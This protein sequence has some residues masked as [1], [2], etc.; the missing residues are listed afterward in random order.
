M[1]VARVSKDA[2]I[3]IKSILIEGKLYDLPHWIPE[4]EFIAGVRSDDDDN[5]LSSLVSCRLVQWV[6]SEGE[7]I[8]CEE[9]EVFSLET[10][11]FE[12]EY[13][14]PIGGVRELLAP[15]FIRHW[16]GDT[17]TV[18]GDAGVTIKFLAGKYV[19]I[20]DIQAIVLP[21]SFIG[22]PYGGT[23]EWMAENYESLQYEFAA[24]AAA[25]T[26]WDGSYE[27]FTTKA[28]EKCFFLF[29]VHQD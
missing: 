10:P 2:A 5:P 11:L 13:F 20:N 26:G 21:M 29:E 15:Y 8:D 22:L 25:A 28:G 14:V 23:G 3:T 7:T 27:E 9:G 1:T 16:S 24:R 6:E 17:E 19:D 4:E 18:I 12:L